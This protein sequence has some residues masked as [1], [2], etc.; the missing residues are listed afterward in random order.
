TVTYF[1]HSAGGKI[2]YLLEEYVGL[3]RKHIADMQR[4]RSRACTILQELRAVL[5]VAERDKS[6]G[7][8]S[9]R[10]AAARAGV[11]LF[12]YLPS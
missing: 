2:K 5:L 12:G 8:R 7:T 1:P 10:V 9:R 11:I 6:V 3:D 4:Q